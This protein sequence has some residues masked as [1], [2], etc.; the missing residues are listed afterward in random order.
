MTGT[1]ISRLV[2]ALIAATRKG[3]VKWREVS[4]INLSKWTE[5]YESEVE[6]YKLQLH[7]NSVRHWGLLVA[8]LLWVDS[9]DVPALLDLAAAVK[10]EVPPAEIVAS[11]LAAL[12]EK[13]S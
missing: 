6:G 11:I 1:L 10:S 7:R 12:E 3:N 13:P 2:Q 8:G 5:L 9:N 4:L